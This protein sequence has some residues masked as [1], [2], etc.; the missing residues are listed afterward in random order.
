MIGKKY[1]VIAKDDLQLDY[2]TWTKGLDYQVVEKGDYF[3]LASNE[4]SVNYLLT[5]KDNVLSEFDIA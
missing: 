3:T 2:H 5:A 4:S 1:K